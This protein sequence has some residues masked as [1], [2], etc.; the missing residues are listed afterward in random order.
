[1]SSWFDK[2][3]EDLQRRQAEQDA[4][5]EGRP[6][7]PFGP[8][9]PGGNGHDQGKG[10]DRSAEDEEPTPFG[11][12]RP[13]V[14]R[15]RGGGSPPRWGLLIGIAVI[16]IVVFGFLGGVVNL[17][18]DVMWYNALDRTSL[19]IVTG[20]DRRFCFFIRRK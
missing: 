8:R 6:I 10:D 19:A 9:R 20:E 4:R 13:R 2:L 15:P 12:R 5:R 18:T 17:I 11:P 16:L 1:M 3:L 14:L 7:P